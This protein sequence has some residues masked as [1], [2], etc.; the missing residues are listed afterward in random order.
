MYNVKYIILVLITINILFATGAEIGKFNY[1]YISLL[2]NSITIPVC[3]AVTE[4]VCDGH[5]LSLYCEDGTNIKIHNARYGRFDTT[6]CGS[7]SNIKCYSSIANAKVKEKCN[8]KKECSFLI[9]PYIFGLP[10][11]QVHKYIEVKYSC[12]NTEE[13]NTE[14]NARRTREEHGGQS[15]SDNTED[16]SMLDN[17]CDPNNPDSC[18]KVLDVP[19]PTKDHAGKLYEEE[20][21][22]CD[23][24]NPK[25]TENCKA[26]D[27]KCSNEKSK[28]CS[29]N[30][31]NCTTLVNPESGSCRPGD[32]TC[33]PPITEPGGC[34]PGD[35]NCKAN[36]KDCCPGNHNCNLPQRETKRCYPSDPACNKAIKPSSSGRCRSGD[37]FCNPPTEN[38]RECNSKN[39]NCNPYQPELERCYPGD[40]LCY[41]PINPRIPQGCRLGHRDCGPQE[42]VRCRPG[43][44]FCEQPI[45]S[46][47]TCRPGDISCN[48]SINQTKPGS[49]HQGDPFCNRPIYQPKP[50]PCYPDDPFCNWP[51]N[52]PRP[53]PCSPGDPFCYPPIHQPEPRPCQPGDLCW[54]SS[55]KECGVHNNWC[56]LSEDK[57]CHPEDLSCNWPPSDE[58]R[59]G[60]P[61]WSM[62]ENCGAHNNWCE[63]RDDKPC[64]PDDP[65]CNWLPFDECRPGDLCW[66]TQE[67][68]S[69]TKDCGVH[70]NGCAQPEDEPCHPDNP[71]CKWLP[72]DECRPGEPCW[73]TQENC[74][75]NNNWCEQSED[76]VC[77]PDDP[78]CNW[79]QPDE[80]QPGDLCWN[81]QKDKSFVKDCGTH[82][83]W[84][85]E[86][87]IK[88]CNSNNP[89]CNSELEPPVA[90]WDIFATHN[91]LCQRNTNHP[92]CNPRPMTI[93][94]SVKPWDIIALFNNL[95][96]SNPKHPSCNPRP[97]AIPE[98]PE[99]DDCGAHNN[100]CQP[101]VN[102]GGEC[103]QGSS[104]SGPPPS[105]TKPCGDLLSSPCQG[106]RPSC[107]TSS[108]NNP[109]L[110]GGCGDANPSNCPFNN[111]C[112]PFSLG[113]CNNH[114]MS[115]PSAMIFGPSTLP[116]DFG[117]P[118]IYPEAGTSFSSITYKLFFFYNFFL[119]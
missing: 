7:S 70:N 109:P 8:K 42:P 85:E 68:K 11:P 25:P 74:G 24:T 52:Q 53:K 102:I 79:P 80:C 88:N 100:W 73:N 41:K 67:D 56:K 91:N 44:R 63:K 57:L 118:S 38:P 95:C 43:D 103:N 96:Q 104:C 40:P 71:R 61:Y 77:H 9:V 107:G 84:C 5:T 17:N 83:N 29:A 99:P 50:R 23:K 92:S 119:F 101:P 58:C 65:S 72:P 110:I 51:I 60:D 86:P 81:M 64:H 45:S 1:Y 89:S 90:S 98:I 28:D 4:T 35:Y 87:E 76:K 6:T 14:P 36:P 12:E 47:R 78:S 59:P 26:N 55:Q 69:F 48:Q 117:I 3:Y 34:R 66:H 27:L 112:T 106:I 46:T 10:C 22:D 15:M 20:S 31:T 114:A 37:R 19:N 116:D 97:P 93:E 2:L 18:V 75:A 105:D 32:S 16:D 21:R 113:S 39:P 33:K 30:N 62:R 94:V 115:A 49:C 111:P 54:I 108:C 13:S 82:N